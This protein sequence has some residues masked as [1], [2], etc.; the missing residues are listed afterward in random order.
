MFSTGVFADACREWRRRPAAEHTWDTFKTHFAL[1]H[2][3]NRLI[4]QH[5]TQGGGF[6]QANNAMDAFVTE[7]A[8]AFANLATAAASDRDVLKTLTNTNNDLLQ[9]L[10]AKDTELTKLRAQLNKPAPAQGHD[11]N[12][13]NNENRPPRDPL[14]KRF[15]NQN[16]CWS[17]GYDI[18]PTHNSSSCNFP[19]DGHK[20]EASRTNILG[21]SLLAKDKIY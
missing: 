18:H 20:K 21:G 9:Q 3:D 12:N 14:K 5:T 6:H 19:R 13:N 17:H 8:G 1:A 11:N 16:Y 15:K 4:Q 7:T 2:E 10:A